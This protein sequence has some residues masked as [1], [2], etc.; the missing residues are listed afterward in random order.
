M[1]RA[2]GRAPRGRSPLTINLVTL[3]FS[4][5]CTH[6]TRTV[7][8][9]TNNRTSNLRR[10][11]ELSQ[12]AYDA[13]LAEQG[14]LCEICREPN[15]PGRGGA[16]RPLSVDH[17]HVTGQNR[18]LLCDACNKALGFIRDS[19]EL[20]IRLLVY[21]RKYQASA[22]PH[23]DRNPETEARRLVAFERS[24]LELPADPSG[25]IPEEEILPAEFAPAAIF[26]PTE[27]VEVPR[28]EFD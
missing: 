10:R 21:L 12:E 22:I 16:S 28:S 8:L 17:D 6:L 23:I 13:Q 7:H 5:G 2:P 1:T 26:S 14:G 3:P 18:G 20:V 24:L 27:Q 15:P 11:Y 4:Q 19:Q 9:V 25:T